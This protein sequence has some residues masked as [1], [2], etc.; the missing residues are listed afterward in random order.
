MNSIRKNIYFVTL[1]F[2]NTSLKLVPT[3]YLRKKILSTVGFSIEKNVTIHRGV[4]ILGFKCVSIGANTTINRDVMIDNRRP[5]FIGDNVM[6][7][8]GVKIYTLGH[9]IHHDEFREKGASVTISDNCVLFAGAVIMPGVELGRGSVIYPETVMYRST[10][11]AEVWCG[12]PA[13]FVKKRRTKVYKYIA[14]YPQWL[15]N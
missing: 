3:F 9:D 7:A 6:V 8:H 15:G 1:Y 11:P 4:R 13:Q 10:K 14:A 12:N 5:I 2:V